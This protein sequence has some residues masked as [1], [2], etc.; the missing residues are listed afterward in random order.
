MKIHY[1]W[2]GNSP[3]NSKIISCIQS[4]KRF[5]PEA[6]I[7]EW[8]ENNLD[9]SICNYVREA[10][11]KKKYAFVSDYYRYYVLYHFGGIYLDTDV[12]LIKSLNDL[13]E[14]FV[15]FETGGRYVASGLIRAAPKNDKICKELLESFHS[16]SFILP[17]GN[18]NLETVCL[19][20][21]RILCKYGLVPNNK[22]QIIRN[23]Y[24][25][26]SDFFCPFDN[27]SNELILTS[28][29]YSIHHYLGSWLDES[30]RAKILLNRDKKRKAKEL[31]RK[32]H[33]PLMLSSFYVFLKHDGVTTTFRRVLDYL[34]KKFYSEY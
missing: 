3:K 23:T 25:Y 29:T 4:W 31:S 2:F 8:N 21:T 33:I 1:C 27:S 12:E 34:S 32:L 17:S 9:L 26:P 22:F 28:N 18:L 13:P 6:E 5:H 11:S 7:I 19:R 14:A 10:Y 16:D 15:G 24:I 30:Q 20:E